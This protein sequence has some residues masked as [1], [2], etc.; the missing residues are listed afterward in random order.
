MSRLKLER[1]IVGFNVI[2]E[3]IKSN[4]SRP[5]LI[6]ILVSL[7]TGALEIDS[8]KAEAIMSFIQAE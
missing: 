6:S 2:Q 3:L 7:F 4:E 8:V 5:K 1:P